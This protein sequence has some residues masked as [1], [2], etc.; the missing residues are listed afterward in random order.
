[1]N[2]FDF[3]PAGIVKQSENTDLTTLATRV[4]DRE[5]RSRKDQLDHAKKQATDVC[6]A[7]LLCK[8]RGTWGP[9]CKE[10]ELSEARGRQYCQFGKAIVTIG[11]SDLSED[12]Q[13]AE[14][15]RISGNTRKEEPEEEM[16][17]EPAV[18]E[19]QA[20]VEAPTLPTPL[21]TTLGR[22]TPPSAP[23]STAPTPSVARDTV[24]PEESEEDNEDDEEELEE[25]TGTT[26]DEAEP[27][28][29]EDVDAMNGK[30][31]KNGEK[32]D[33]LLD[34]LK[35]AVKCDKVSKD[36]IADRFNLSKEHCTRSLSAAAM[37]RGYLVTYVGDGEF[38]VRRAAHF[39]WREEGGESP[40]NLQEAHEKL[41]N[42]IEMASNQSSL[43]T[44]GKEKQMAFIREAE[45]I[46]RELRLVGKR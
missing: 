1:M 20:T 18:E 34:I 26:A 44:W 33:I 19:P 7:R 9:W 13:W 35:W 43:L 30:Q 42:L 4:R 5:K 28:L 11:F 21:Q 29:G 2:E 14:W 38:R 46:V 37:S 12:D 3:K 45:R 8:K 23:R 41:Y 22:V 25:E 6:A 16:E 31:P 10:A 36:Q 15:Q 39:V 24:E 32:R 17:E 40:K 27:E